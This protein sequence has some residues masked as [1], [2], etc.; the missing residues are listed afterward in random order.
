MR[1]QITNLFNDGGGGYNHSLSLSGNN[2]MTRLY[3]YRES[4]PFLKYNNIREYDLRELAIF[5]Q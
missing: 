1:T 3:T 2:W 4:N 5:L